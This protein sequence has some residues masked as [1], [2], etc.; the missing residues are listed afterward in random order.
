MQR[1][2]ITTKH[3]STVTAI[4][5]LQSIFQPID[6]WK[7]FAFVFKTVLH[8][9]V[10]QPSLSR[11]GQS[12]TENALLDLTLPQDPELQRSTVD[13]SLRC[14]GASA[15]AWR[16]AAYWERKQ[17]KDAFCAVRY[18]SSVILCQAHSVFSTIDAKPVNLM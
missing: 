5:K 17:F 7:Y 11:V 9:I 2:S 14:T 18:Q 6:R 13:R 15:R 10:Y 8:G 16:C 12:H 1:L 3:I 4:K